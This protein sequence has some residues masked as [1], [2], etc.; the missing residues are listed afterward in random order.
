MIE[1]LD[2]TQRPEAVC[3]TVREFCRRLDR[4]VVDSDELVVTQRV[5][6]PPGSY[7]LNTRN[8]LALR[9]ARHQ[10]IEKQPGQSVEYVVADDAASTIDRVRLAHEA[11]GTIDTEFYRTQLLRAAA[12]VLSPL[13]WRES[14][15]E[16]YLAERR[17]ASLLEY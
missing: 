2:T 14:D 13:G 6:K 16:Q 8:V 17:T 4:G 1:T 11:D 5:S 10:G 7:H 15:I 12:S 9:R 3:N